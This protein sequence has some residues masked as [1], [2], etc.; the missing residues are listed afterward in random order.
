MTPRLSALIK[1][2]RYVAADSGMRHAASL[3]ITPEIWI[4]DFDSAD[5]QLIRQ[6]PDIKRQHYS[7]DKNATD[8]AL[9]ISYATDKAAQQIILV[10]A[11]GGRSDHAVAHFMQSIDLARSGISNICT[12][13]IEEVWPLIPTTHK[14]DFPAGTII[15]II[16]LSDISGLCISEVK[17]PLDNAN[18]SIGSTLAL[19]NVIIA[20]AVVSMKTGYGLLVIQTS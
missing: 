19:S 12:N 11:Q 9:A 16:A 8:G 18:L 3:G 17:W 15:S 4:G 2:G 5:E 10:G 14:L 6:Y 1:G 13:G 20:N 7:T